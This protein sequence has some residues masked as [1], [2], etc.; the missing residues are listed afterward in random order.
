LGGSLQ[1]NLNVAIDNLNIFY[2]NSKLQK[3]IDKI[4]EQSLVDAVNAAQKEI[5]NFNL[6]KQ[7]FYRAK[8]DEKEQI[9][10]K[11]MQEDLDFD[12]KWDYLEK[13]GYII[14][15]QSW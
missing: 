2:A 14:P 3:N 11:R 15:E 10:K 1:D 6:Q 5:D 9:F 8:Q 7:A 12:K 13:E 4:Q